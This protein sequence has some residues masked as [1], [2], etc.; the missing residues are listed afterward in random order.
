M[1]PVCAGSALEG[2]RLKQTGAGSLSRETGGALGAEVS[3]EILDQQEGSGE[4][5]RRWPGYAGGSSGHRPFSR[6]PCGGQC[7]Q[8]EMATSLAIIP[9]R[10]ICAFLEHLLRRLRSP[11]VHNPAAERF[12]FV[13]DHGPSSH[14]T[15]TPS[16]QAQRCPAIQS[17]S[18]LLTQPLAF[19]EVEIL[20][21]CGPTP[22]AQ[23]ANFPPSP[24]GLSA[25]GGEI[26]SSPCLSFPLPWL[27]LAPLTPF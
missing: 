9:D 16:T 5:V 19:S 18:Y 1:E 23:F 6:C 20:G 17:L 2:R 3:N 22:V 21:S 14:R 4:A 15:L 27:F 11:R 12:C 8:L 24:V 26:F 7:S 10:S 25:R 13:F